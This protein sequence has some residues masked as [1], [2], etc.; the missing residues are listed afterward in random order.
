MRNL[1]LTALLLLITGWV[2]EAQVQ[3]SVGNY[4]RYGNGQQVSGAGENQF[5]YLE[6]QTNVRLFWNDFTIGM[7]YLYDDPPEFGPRYQGVKKRY[8]EFSREGLEL[9]AGD[10]YTLYGKGMAMNLFENRGINYDTG[11]DGLRGSY[12]NDWFKVIT[13]VGTLKYYDLNRPELIEDYKIKSGHLTISPLSFL[14]VGGSLVGV[15][16]ELPRTL[17][18]AYLRAEIHELMVSAR[19]AGFELFANYAQKK[20]WGTIESSTLGTTAFD[21]TGEGIY[22]SLG[23]SSPSGFGFTFEYKDYKF[24]PVDPTTTKSDA[25]RPTR[26]LPIQNPPTAFKEHGFYFLSRNPHMIDFSDEVGMQLDVF[27]SL[28]PTITLNING[29]MSS[30]QKAYRVRNGQYYAVGRDNFLPAVGT[31]YAPFYE[32]YTEVEWYFSGQ[33]YVRT[34]LNKRY[35]VQS[36][37]G[38][39]KP[40]HLVSSFT[41]PTRIEYMLDDVYSVTLGFEEQWYHDTQVVQNVDYY[42]QYLSFTFTKAAVYSANLRME[43]TTDETDQSGKKFWI[44]GEVTY[45]L[46]STHTASISYGSERGGLVCSSGICRNVLPFE[47]VRVSLLTQL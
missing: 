42:N 32:L 36:Y 28:T 15:D 11:L 9:R 44:T 23:Y 45:R 18:T 1:L 6:N 43:Y 5:E 40:I 16:G 33:S 25:G 37:D 4:S 21:R 30:R 7:Q 2:V 31:A 41:F 27:Y 34:A 35:D 3:Y 39:G 29:S 24:D 14:S 26:A 12:Q 17:S 10:F 46:G 19:M 8:V 47:G 22:G 20:S 38:V 13:A